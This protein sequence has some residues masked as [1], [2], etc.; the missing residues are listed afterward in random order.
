[1]SVQIKLLSNSARTPNQNNDGS[2]DIYSSEEIILK[3]NETINIRTGLIASLPIGYYGLIE[4]TELVVSHN[5]E[6]SRFCSIHY[7]GDKKNITV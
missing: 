7:H 6:T 5:I 1:M 3:P 2:Y 4:S